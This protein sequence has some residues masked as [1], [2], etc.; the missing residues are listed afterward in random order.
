MCSS[1][2]FVPYI[3]WNDFWP[4]HEKKNR[5]CLLVDRYILDVSLFESGNEVGA[6]VKNFSDVELL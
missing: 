1:L 5:A 3:I 2:I 4:T 6:C